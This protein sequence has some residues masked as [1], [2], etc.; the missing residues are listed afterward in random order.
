MKLLAIS[1]AALIM[2][3]IATGWLIIAKRYLS[4][5]IIERIIHDDEKIVKAHIDYLMMSL[6]LFVFFF[7]GINMPFAVILMSCIGAFANP[8][9]FIFLSIKPDVNKNMGSAFSL[10]S[11]ITFLITTAGIGGGAFYIIMELIK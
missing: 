10:I 8:S 4:L 9:L 2:L 5:G 3:S 1:G 7:T 11:T 6:I